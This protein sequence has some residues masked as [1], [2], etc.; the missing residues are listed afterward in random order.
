MPPSGGAAIVAVPVARLGGD[1]VAVA[2]ASR[3]AEVGSL[4]QGCAAGG[5]IVAMTTA[6]GACRGKLVARRLHLVPHEPVAVAAPA[7]V[8]AA[9]PADRG[10]GHG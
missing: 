10:L 9:A 4:V 6:C 3:V 5:A 1:A 7:A 8:A 2:G